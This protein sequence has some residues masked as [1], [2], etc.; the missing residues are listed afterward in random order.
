MDTKL[1]GFW[2]NKSVYFYFHFDRIDMIQGKK[3]VTLS[4]C[5]INAKGYLTF[6][7]IAVLDTYNMRKS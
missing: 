7:Q 3:V 1:A 4:K 2:R 5:S 6:D